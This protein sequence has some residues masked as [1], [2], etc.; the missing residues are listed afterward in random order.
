MSGLPAGGILAPVLWQIQLAIDEGMAAGGDVGEKDPDLAIFD[1]AGEATVL[2]PDP[3][4]VLA[5]LGDG[6]FIEGQ[7]RED[8]LGGSLLRQD[9]GRLQ[10]LF[11]KG[12]QLIAN[13]VLV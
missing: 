13:P 4:R 3:G 11:D 12:P 9:E 7:H 1:A 2:R 6:T 8:R 10:G 5:A